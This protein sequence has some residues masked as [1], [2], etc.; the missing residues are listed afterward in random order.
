MSYGT[1]LHD[2]VKCGDLECLHV[3]LRE[4]PRVANSPSETDPR[5]TYSL[6]VAA[7]FGQARLHESGSI[8]R[9]FLA[10]RQR[11]RFHR[12]WF[13]QPSS[14]A[15]TLS[16]A[17]KPGFAPDLNFIV[18]AVVEDNPNGFRRHLRRFT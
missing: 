17:R 3:L 14:V 11:E 13:G 16:K 9:G 5:G 6:H 1:V 18:R 7:E 8:T 2:A 10:P 4:D 12:S 15:R